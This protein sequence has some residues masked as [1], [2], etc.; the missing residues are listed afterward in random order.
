MAP[1]V[2]PAPVPRRLNLEMAGIILVAVF[3]LLTPLYIYPVFLMKAMCY[4]ILGMSVNLLL[5]YAGMLSF[6]HAAFFGISAYFFGYV[7]KEFNIGVLP[8][9]LV[10]VAGGTMLGV[11]FAA[12]AVRRIEFYFAMTTLA[13]AQLVYFF[14]VQ[15]PFTGGDDGLQG[16]PRGEIF[17]FSL[18]DNT[19]LYIFVLTIFMLCLLFTYRVVNSPFGEI[20][21]AIRE[22]PDRVK[23]LGENP[24][25]YKF[26][27][28]VLSAFLASIGG[29]LKA[30]VFQI[31][32]LPDTHWLMSGDGVLMAL[33]GGIGTL[34][35]P[36]VGALFIVAAQDGLAEIGISIVVLQGVLFIATV[37]MFRKGIVGELARFKKW[38]E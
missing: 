33:V 18:R 24:T 12:I 17:G 23:S 9:L 7:A 19:N 4:A 25:S 35:G 13:L 27:A 26:I 22:N 38:F 2:A 20:L 30:L 31:A 11:V 37:L 16:I 29:A 5:G 10:A 32:A 8:S 15:A 34:I 3:F 28:F 21:T 14:C 36:I 1:A 6:G